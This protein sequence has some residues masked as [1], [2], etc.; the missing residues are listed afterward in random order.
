MKV[1]LRKASHSEVEWE[2]EEEEEEEEEVAV[3]EREEA[4]QI[5]TFYTSVRTAA[6]SNE[7]YIIIRFL[8]LGLIG[9]YSYK[10]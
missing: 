1:C 9:W 5:S 8:V 10:E 6:M 4:S 7:R 3:E 2:E